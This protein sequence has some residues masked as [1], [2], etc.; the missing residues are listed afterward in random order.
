MGIRDR[1]RPDDVTLH[2]YDQWRA[3]LGGEIQKAARQGVHLT[4]FQDTLPRVRRTLEPFNVP[5]RF[6]QGDIMRA[7]WNGEPISVYVD[8]CSK[9]LPLFCHSVATFGPS[10]IPGQTVILLMDFDLW[11]TTGLAEFEFQKRFVEVAGRCFEPMQLDDSASGTVL[12]AFRYKAPLGAGEWA[13]LLDQAIDA[14]GAAQRELGVMRLRK[15]VKDALRLSWKIA[16]SGSLRN[17]RNRRTAV[18][19]SGRPFS[20]RNWERNSRRRH[21]SRYSCRR[22]GMS[23]VVGNQAAATGASNSSTSCLV[24]SSSRSALRSVLAARNRTTAGIDARCDVRL[25]PKIRTMRGR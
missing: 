7:A 24:C 6:H 22:G 4:A 10:W 3:Q 16:R 20:G 12:A 18:S 11:K 1:E 5:I 21:V 2:C 17:V 14:L 13:W 8:D 9:Q 19:N 25:A 15:E 23:R